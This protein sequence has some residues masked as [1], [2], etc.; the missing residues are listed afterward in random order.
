[1]SVIEVSALRKHSSTLTSHY[2]LSQVHFVLCVTHVTET[3][4]LVPSKVYR[5]WRSNKLLGFLPIYPSHK[6]EHYCCVDQVELRAIFLLLQ[7]WSETHCVVQVASSCL[8]LQ[9]A[10]VQEGAS[11]WGWLWVERWCLGGVGIYLF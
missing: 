5:P 9:R 8:S 7:G 2:C 3:S 6:T 10:A 4:P 1:M 11:P